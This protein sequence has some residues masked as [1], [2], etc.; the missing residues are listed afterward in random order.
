MNN[1]SIEL[2]FENDV[3]AIDCDIFTAK[4]LCSPEFIPSGFVICFD[5]DFELMLYDITF[6]QAIPSTEA[7]KRIESYL[8]D[9]M[10]L[11]TEHMLL[12]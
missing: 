4:F 3:H 1:Y 6:K 10:L 9:V 5:R 7:L 8:N 11:H 12:Q 2:N